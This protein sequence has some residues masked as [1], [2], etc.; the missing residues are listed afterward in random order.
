MM[1]VNNRNVRLNQYAME[2][3]R[4]GKLL[5]E[6]GEELGVGKE[7][8]RV[9]VV[10]GEIFEKL[11]ERDKNAKTMGDLFLSARLKNVIKNLGAK[12]M[13]FTQFLEN[14]SQ[15]TLVE[16]IHIG[17]AAVKEI[18]YEL[19]KKNVPEKTI[20]DWI[21]VEFKK[22]KKPKNKRCDAGIPNGPEEKHNTCQRYVIDEGR[23]FVGKLCN[24][25]LR[26]M[27]KKY[28]TKHK[29]YKKPKSGTA[30]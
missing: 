18:L 11:C 12:N 20:Q 25:P 7:R 5:R 27:Q 16:T 4:S 21:N 2:L 28:C 19:R 8:A 14:I 9:R 10:M 1:A 13:T 29:T 3:R 30:E 6:I 24:E 23:M 17:K 26:P 22:V 15:Q